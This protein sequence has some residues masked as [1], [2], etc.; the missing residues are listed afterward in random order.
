MHIIVANRPAKLG[1]GR[2]NERLV[3]KFHFSRRITMAARRGSISGFVIAGAA[4]LVLFGLV[5]LKARVN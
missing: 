5:I 1:G 3:S 4:L 2:R